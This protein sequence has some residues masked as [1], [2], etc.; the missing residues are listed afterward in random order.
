MMSQAREDAKVVARGA[1]VGQPVS[2]CNLM[3][4]TPSHLPPKNPKKKK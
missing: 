2:I 4:W 3:S 1:A